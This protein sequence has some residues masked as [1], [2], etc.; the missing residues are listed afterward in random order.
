M[1]LCKSKYKKCDYCFKYTNIK[2][3]YCS[4]CLSNKLSTIPDAHSP[5][6]QNISNIVDHTYQPQNPKLSSKKNHSIHNKP[7]TPQYYTSDNDDLYIFADN[8]GDQS[9]S[10]GDICGDECSFG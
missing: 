10:S 6:K 1:G 9:N 4:S 2:L 8:Y 5:T 3:T 7:Q